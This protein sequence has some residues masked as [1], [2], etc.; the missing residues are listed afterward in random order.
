MPTVQVRLPIARNLKKRSDAVLR[1]LGLDAG[2]FA[3]EYALTPAQS[4]RAGAALRRE[5]AR[6]RLREVAGPADLVP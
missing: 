5:T 3:T 2:Y 4:A 6:G 1:V